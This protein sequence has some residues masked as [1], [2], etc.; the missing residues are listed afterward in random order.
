VLDPVFAPFS[1]PSPPE[2]W[3]SFTVPIGKWLSGIG[4]SPD[5]ALNVRTYALCILVGIVAAVILTSRRLT[6][7]G[8]EPGIV[9][10]IALWA[11]PFGIVGARVYHVLTHPDDYF[12]KGKDFV[13]VFYIWE[14][15]I[16]IFG[17][18]LFGAVGAYIGC[19]FAGIRFWS[20]ADA[21]AP[22]L[23]L[24]QAFGRFGNY[25]NQELFGQPTDLPWGL[26][27]D[28]PNAA[29]P[30]G[31]PDSTLFHPTF[32]YEILWN[33]LGLVI[34]LLLE[35]EYRLRWG[36][37]FSLY[38]IWYGIG[39]VWF[40]S[41]RIDPSEVFLGLR[42]NVWGALGALVLGVVI[43]IV[44]TRRHPGTEPSPYRPGR[45]WSPAA[46]GVDFDDTY[47]DTDDAGD[48]AAPSPEIA[49]TSGAGA[50]S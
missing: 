47:S 17:A 2:S 13:H 35:R 29:I 5:Y 39:R 7:R 8:A 45:E 31:L 16:A 20:F 24:A 42:T 28:R 46:S 27:I 26:Q 48:D 21:L 22:G 40:E 11:V 41:I 43:L 44:Q 33:V 30:I 9:L 14:G 12:G 1:L 10:D 38:L 37:M 6:K 32:L 36:K 3:A 18:L 4:V 50:S 49:A 25:F 19:R 34:I 15:G 23:L